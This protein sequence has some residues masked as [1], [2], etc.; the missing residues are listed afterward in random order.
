VDA[1]SEPIVGRQHELDRIDLLLGGL[2]IGVGGCVVFTAPAGGGKSFLLDHVARRCDERRVT[3]CRATAEAGLVAPFRLIATALGLAFGDGSGM[4]IAS[5]ASFFEAGV[6]AG[7]DGASIERL[8]ERLDRLALAAPTV[9]LLDDIHL[10]DP[11]SVAFLEVVLDRLS[12][13]PVGLVLAGRTGVRP[14]P[15]D[16]W[17]PRLERLADVYELGPLDLASVSEMCVERFGAPPGERLGRALAASNGS[18]L[19]A[20]TTLDAAAD[21]GVAVRNGAVDIAGA[22]EHELLRSIPDPVRSRLESV[23]GPDGLVAAATAIAGATFTVADVADILHAPLIQVAGVVERLE[24]A[25]IVAADGTVH[26]YRHEFFRRAA[27]RCVSTSM[28]ASLHQAMVGVL[29]SRGAAPLDVADH[30]VA[31][32]MTGS[33]VADWLRQAAELL[34]DT[35]PGAALQLIERAFRTTHAPSRALIRAHMRVLSSLGRVAEADALVQILLTDAAPAEEIELRR[36]HA[37]GLFR[38]GRTD[39]SIRELQRASLLTSDEVGRSRFAAEEAFMRLMSGDFDA[40]AE[41]SA[42]AARAVVDPDDPDDPERV[43]DVVTLLAAHMVGALV[44][45]YRVE[46]DEA[47][48]MADQMVALAELPEARGAALYQ[49]WFSAS[50]V[51]FELGRFALAHR[52]NNIGRA[53]S[54]RE[55]H[56]WAVAGYDTLDAACHFQ[57]GNWDD[58]EASASAAL[59]AEI[60]DAYGANLWCAA[61]LART[62]LVRGDLSLARD[63]IDDARSR[64]RPAQAQLGLDHLAMAEAALLAADGKTAEAGALVDAYWDAFEAW[65]ID[66][67]RQE[68]SLDVVSYAAARG[69]DDRVRRAIEHLERVADRA[70]RERFRLDAEL[71]RWSADEL[72]DRGSAMARAEQRHRLYERYRALGFG[73]RLQRLDRPATAASVTPPPGLAGPL[74]RSE[75]AVVELVAQGC[76]NS[77]IAERLFISRRTVESHVSSAYRKLGVGNRVELARRWAGLAA[78]G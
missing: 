17:W 29:T 39:E 53:R 13:I 47:E 60:V 75:A 25:G 43:S 54:T 27:E 66:L 44:S 41:R 35:D 8:L 58:V 74:T 30:V 16:R 1:G 3:T 23:V 31:S 55:G 22:A 59:A 52:V 78:P 10:A 38:E 12:M 64:V 19:L 62:A 33:V 4:S 67:P 5:T 24:R 56:F 7:T 37:V 51:D 11:G 45:L 57:E 48:R 72:A 61:L 15:L 2:E 73:L 9:L 34:A 50:I 40:A 36:E 63:R 20:A 68:L 14:T 26:R 65:G 6:G 76:T 70:G 32:G 49:P 21:S 69:D 77:A 46:L 71:A 18:P 42:A 28:L